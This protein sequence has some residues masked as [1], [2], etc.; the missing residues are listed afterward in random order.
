MMSTQFIE[1]VTIST[2]NTRCLRRG[3]LGRRK[4]KEIR[5]VFSQTTPGTDIL[6][7]QETKL[8]EEAGQFE[9]SKIYRDERWNEPM[10]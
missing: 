8:P 1:E 3:F 5:S 2:Q 4:R 10:E 6:L 9:T 7:L